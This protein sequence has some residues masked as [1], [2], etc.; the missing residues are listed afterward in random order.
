MRCD[1]AVEAVP[2]QPF[3]VSETGWGEFE[4]NIKLHYVTES[5]EKPQ[6]V[7]HGLRLH[8]YGTDEERA[9]QKASGEVLAWLYEEQ[10]FNEPYENFYDILTTGAEKAKGKVGGAKKKNLGPGT[11]IPERTALIPMRS[12]PGQPYSREAEQLEVKRLKDARA[13]VEEQ[14]KA[15][16][17]LLREKEAQLAALRAA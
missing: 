17:Q 3:Q 9:A 2:G 4:I 7:W 16:T 6:S 10:L 15:M 14:N 12:S 5:S 8:A 11:S 13:K 1:V